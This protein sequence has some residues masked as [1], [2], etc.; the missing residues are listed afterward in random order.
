MAVYRAAA[1]KPHHRF[2]ISVADLRLPLNQERAD[3]AIMLAVLSGLLTAGEDPAH[4]V[5]L[6]EAGR[7]LL[8]QRRMID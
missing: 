2:Y 4:S 3:A 6:T 8:R 1:G 7:G 5:A